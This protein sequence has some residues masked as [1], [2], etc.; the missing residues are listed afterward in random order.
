[1]H[2]PLLKEEMEREEKERREEKEEREE[3]DGK[4]EKKRKEMQ[5]ALA[6]AVHLPTHCSS[7][8]LLLLLLLPFKTSA[9]MMKK[10]KFQAAIEISMSIHATLL[11]Y[12][13]PFLLL[14]PLLPYKI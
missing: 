14:L 5:V 4:E 10:V 13:M 12:L 6:P 1:M 3:K 9:E 11:I 7:Y 8:P 2:W